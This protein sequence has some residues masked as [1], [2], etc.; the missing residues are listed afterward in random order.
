VNPDFAG[1]SLPQAVILRVLW[2]ATQPCSFSM[3]RPAHS[4][5]TWTVIN[6]LRGTTTIVTIAYRFSALRQ[7]DLVAVL[8]KGR[9]VRSGPW[10]AVMEETRD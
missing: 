1:A 9:I 3:K 5:A 4:C 2:C 10:Q 6:R 7:A 8:E